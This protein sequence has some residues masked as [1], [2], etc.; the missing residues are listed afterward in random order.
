[1]TGGCGGKGTWGGILDMDD[2]RFVD[3]NDPNYSSSEVRLSSFFTQNSNILT[4]LY[5]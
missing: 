3:S 1:M 4:F 5:P 2:N